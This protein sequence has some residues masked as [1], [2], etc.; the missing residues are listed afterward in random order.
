MKRVDLELKRYQLSLHFLRFRNLRCTDFIGIDYLAYL[1]RKPLILTTYN[2]QFTIFQPVIWILT[3][4]AVFVMA[5]IFK[6]IYLVY[7]KL[8]MKYD[9]WKPVTH[10]F[11]F[12]LFSFASL[13]GA[14]TISWFPRLSTG[15]TNVILML[16]FKIT[17]I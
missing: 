17:P 3:L 8:D 15:K 12:I 6:T 14:D 1:G 5:L 4:V 10:Q 16:I 9:L 13:T 11:D 7:S 2:Q